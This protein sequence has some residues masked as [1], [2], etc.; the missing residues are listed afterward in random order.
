M[1]LYPK[2]K[3]FISNKRKEKICYCY[4]R[5]CDKT[6]I[7]SDTQERLLLVLNITS[8]FGCTTIM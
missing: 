1:I 3:N 5:E 4:F 7:R 6:Y 2:K 8:T